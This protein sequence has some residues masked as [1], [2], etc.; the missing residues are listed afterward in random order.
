MISE[1]QKLPIKFLLLDP[2]NW[3]RKA[4]SGNLYT[5]IFWTST[6]TTVKEIIAIS[7]IDQ[8]WLIWIKL[9]DKSADFVE[10]IAASVTECIG[11]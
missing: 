2:L 10:I 3:T 6:R 1:Y 9:P 4:Y 5:F 7:H 8:F 11:S